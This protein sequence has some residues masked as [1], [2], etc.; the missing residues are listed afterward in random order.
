MPLV[1]ICSALS[2]VNL[3]GLYPTRE[4]IE[5]ARPPTV[6]C[7]G[8]NSI[9]NTHYKCGHFNSILVYVQSNW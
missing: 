2:Y 9:R 8:D 4:A 5:N 1:T 3:G 6:G 7:V